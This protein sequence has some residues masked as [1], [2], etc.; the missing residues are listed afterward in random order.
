[1]SSAASSASLRLSHAQ[2]WKDAG[3]R[4]DEVAL[5]LFEGRYVAALRLAKRAAKQ[6]QEAAGPEHPV[7]EKL[8]KVLSRR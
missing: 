3:G 1:M 8:D 2:S 7:S 6:L 4:L 5:A